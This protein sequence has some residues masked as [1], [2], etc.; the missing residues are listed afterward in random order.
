MC[1][2][3]RSSFIIFASKKLFDHLSPCKQHC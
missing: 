2:S 3:S 1:S